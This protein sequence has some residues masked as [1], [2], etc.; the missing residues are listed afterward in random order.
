[1]CHYIRALFDRII[2]TMLL[3][4]GDN[5]MFGVTHDISPGPRIISVINMITAFE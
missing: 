3:D 4:M 2:C 5:L 1:M